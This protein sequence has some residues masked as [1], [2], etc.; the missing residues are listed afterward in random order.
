M[1][2]RLSENE[3]DMVKN[4]P[5]EWR[6]VTLLAGLWTPRIAARSESVGCC[7]KEMPLQ[8]GMDS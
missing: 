6:D 3:L 7:R 2:R 8:L 4:Y 1:H 5:R